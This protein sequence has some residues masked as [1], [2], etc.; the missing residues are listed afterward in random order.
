MKTLIDV[1]INR[2]LELESHDPHSQTT[3]HLDSLMQAVRLQGAVAVAQAIDAVFQ[4]KSCTTP[5]MQFYQERWRLADE[6]FSL[7]LHSLSPLQPIGNPVDQI[8]KCF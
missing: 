1:K 2:M 3:D 8:Y 6:L 7:L 5:V 4:Y